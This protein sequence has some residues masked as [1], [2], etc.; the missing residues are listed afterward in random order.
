MQGRKGAEVAA[1]KLVDSGEAATLK[2][3]YS[4]RARKAAEA[5]AQII[6]D[7]GEAATLEEAWSM[8][9]RKGAEAAAQKLVDS[10]EAA[11]LKEAYSLQ[12]RK[13]AE[14]A[15][16]KLVD[17][18]D[19]A[20]LEEAYSLQGR[21]RAEAAAQTLVDS[22]EAAT[23]EE[24]YSLQG[25][26]AQRGLVDKHGKDALHRMQS[27]RSVRTAKQ[28]GLRTKYPGVRW[29]KKQDRKT[30]KSLDDG[31][32]DPEMTRGF[33]RVCF[34]YQ[35]KFYSVGSGYANEEEAARAHD[36]YVRAN[37][38]SR[39]LH[40]PDE[41]DGSNA[42]DATSN[43]HR[44]RGGA[45]IP[46][47]KSDIGRAM[48][49]FISFVFHPKLRSS[50]LEW[51]GARQFLIDELLGGA[52]TPQSLFVPVLS[53]TLGQCIVE[54]VLKF[55][56]SQH[57]NV[58]YRSNSTLL[59]S[60]VIAP[61]GEEVKFRLGLHYPCGWLFVHGL[62]QIIPRSTVVAAYAFLIPL[63]DRLL[64][65]LIG[66]MPPLLSSVILRAR[67][68]YAT[69]LFPICVYASALTF[70]RALVVTSR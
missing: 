33:W 53:A 20:T 49:E 40:F 63:S 57:L 46:Y 4:L 2:E 65:H 8:I 32:V 31:P 23:L 24:A 44:L 58:S 9:G 50:A 7:S 41:R 67:G 68:L 61:V 62:V 51:H 64:A 22:G 13:G 10:G 11:T 48:D 21:I 36:A 28:R 39:R 19:V 35:G 16:Q 30:H 15:A 1:Q 5:A 38:M 3:A 26:R 12:A 52:L 59:R 56:L 17:S 66:H 47:R 37:G 6:V 18:G 54:R 43:V 69:R 14:A 25:R 29:Q 45:L 70:A 55:G 60:A 42:T 34:S 27:D